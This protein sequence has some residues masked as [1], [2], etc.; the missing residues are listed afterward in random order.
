MEL[1]DMIGLA[2]KQLFVEALSQAF[3]E[4]VGHS[5]E[6]LDYD[7][8]YVDDTLYEYLVVTYDGGAI[9]ARNCYGDSLSA[10]FDEI[11]RLFNGG[12]YDE[13]SDYLVLKK[14]A[15]PFDKKFAGQAAAAPYINK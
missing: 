13:V 2:K 4:S 6:K 10:I 1:H 8:F 12:Y 9:A 11:A 5:I 14:K 7:I 3:N 15:A